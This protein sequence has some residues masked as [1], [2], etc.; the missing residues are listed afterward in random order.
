MALGDNCTS[1][2][3]TRDHATWGECA[4]GKGLRIG[5][6]NSAN[7]SD[8]STQKRWDADLDF[9]KSTRAQ[10]IQPSG[11]DR[12]AVQRA[13]DISDATGRAYQAS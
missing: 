9:Y 8:L 2:C 1:A 11:T 5:Y 6:A 10:G 7:G 4:R 3:Q 13:L 12:A